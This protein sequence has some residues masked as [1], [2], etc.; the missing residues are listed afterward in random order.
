MKWKNTV[1]IS[2]VP[3]PP[4]FSHKIPSKTGQSEYHLH[5][6][7]NSRGKNVPERTHQLNNTG[8]SFKLPSYPV[9]G[10]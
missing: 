8:N 6:G 4:K 5:F 7:Q 10:Y 2:D 3:T 1:K 9:A